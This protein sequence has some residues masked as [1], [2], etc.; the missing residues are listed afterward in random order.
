MTGRPAGG[1]VS[2]ADTPDG[3]T[4]T[5]TVPADVNRIAEIRDFVRAAAVRAG[6]GAEVVADAVQAIDEAA[7]N[8]VVHGYAGRPGTIEVQ[9]TVRDGRLELRLLDRSP[10]FDPLT[11]PEPNLTVPPLARRPGGMGV[12]LIRAAT[13][14]RRHRPRA[15]GGNELILVCDVERRARKERAMSLSIRSVELTAAPGVT[16]LALEGELD[17]S[18]YEALIERVRSAYAAGARRLVLDLAGLTF[19]AS[20]GLVAL[21]SAVRIMHGDPPPDLE[22]GWSVIHE[23]E[24]DT[25]AASSDVR[26]AAVQPAVERVLDR[27]GLTRL[28]HVDATREAA[29]AALAEG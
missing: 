10:V 11:V 20:S 19:M 6:A 25:E 29:A 27:T 14:E 4:E 21:Y 15:G 9:T 13:D 7:T 24:D 26:L 12:H 18:N 5:L 3:T 16:V 23:I 22:A 17:A 1:A 8:V 2:A 28:F